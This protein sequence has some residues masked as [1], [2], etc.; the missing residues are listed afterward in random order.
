MYGNYKYCKTYFICEDFIFVLF[1][2][3]IAIQK[4]SSP[5]ISNEYLYYRRKYGEL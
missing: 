2:K 1:Y 5:I 3:G 4:K